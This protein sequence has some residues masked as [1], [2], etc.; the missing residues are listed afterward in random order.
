MKN[1]FKLSFDEAVS[2]FHTRLVD[3]FDDDIKALRAIVGDSDYTPRIH[4]DPGGGVVARF[5][6]DKKILDIHVD[7]ENR[8]PYTWS[9]KSGGEEQMGGTA[10]I[11]PYPLLESWLSESDK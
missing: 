8:R 3:L 4:V 2:E 5:T 6:N 9:A 11:C 10:D 1:P 7:I